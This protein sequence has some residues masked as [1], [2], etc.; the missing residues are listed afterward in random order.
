MVWASLSGRET[1]AWGPAEFL[2]L[3]PASRMGPGILIAKCRQLCGDVLVT[4]G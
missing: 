2:G 1:Q 3:L 4:F